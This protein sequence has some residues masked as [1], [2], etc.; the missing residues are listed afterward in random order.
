MQI[1]RIDE[2]TTLK[3]EEWKNSA[4]RE[5]RGIGAGKLIKCAIKNFISAQHDAAT[6]FCQPAYLYAPFGSY[7]RNFVTKI[8]F[9]FRAI[10]RLSLLF[11]N[12]S[13]FSLSLSLLS[14]TFL[15][16]ILFAHFVLAN[17]SEET[18]RGIS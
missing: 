4:M 2:S 12:W 11:G 14:F 7:A 17:F 9:P 10:V 18:I 3:G 13:N 6:C 1:E 15:S 16:S 5:R 8:P